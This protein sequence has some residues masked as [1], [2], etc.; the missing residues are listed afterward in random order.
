M[1]D[2]GSPT[3]REP[4]QGFTLVEVLLVV[5]I[6][7]LITS[8]IAAAIMIVLRTTPTTELR[9]DDA[10]STRSLATWM[11][12]DVASTPGYQPPHAQLGGF[13]NAGN[14]CNAPGTTVVEMVWHEFDRTFVASY[15]LSPSSLGMQLHRYSCAT[16]GSASGVRS[17]LLASGL[18]ND[19][20]AIVTYRR[21]G[22]GDEHEGGP[23]TVVEFRLRGTSGERVVVDAASRNPAEFFPT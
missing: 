5:V 8:S 7:A 3:R 23:V 20:P 21:A 10:R 1:G 14:R 9:I 19:H 15:R 11:S 13:D 2:L 17:T 12:H 6:T 22:A 4:D 18:S 16:G